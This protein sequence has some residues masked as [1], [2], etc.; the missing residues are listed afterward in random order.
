MSDAV[1]VSTAR[2]ALWQNPLSRRTKQHPQC[3]MAGLWIET[4]RQAAGTI[5]TG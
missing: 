1:I 3:R 2:T 4:R 5:L